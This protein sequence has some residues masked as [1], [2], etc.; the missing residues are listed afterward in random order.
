MCIVVRLA[1]WRARLPSFCK[2]RP[3][4]NSFG[5]WPAL[6]KIER[7][8]AEGTRYTPK[9][10]T[11][12]LHSRNSCRKCS[13]IEETWCFTYTNRRQNLPRSYW[14]LCPHST[15][16]Q[17]WPHREWINGL[18]CQAETFISI[19]C[20]TGYKTAKKMCFKKLRNGRYEPWG[21]QKFSTSKLWRS[22]Q[23]LLPER[24]HFLEGAADFRVHACNFSR[25]MAG[26]LFW[27]NA[28]KLPER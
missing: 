20:V 18:L 16:S 3:D 10:N 9:T 15:D 5:I 25:L 2:C 6:F 1:A 8:S 22:I 11:K 24:L 12:V 23:P 28:H 7:E 17:L 21:V 13:Q 14:Q 4:T 27:P 26:D 19:A